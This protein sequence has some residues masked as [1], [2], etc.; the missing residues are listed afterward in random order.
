MRQ[1]DR[2]FI[3]LGVAILV[4]V[5]G[6][7][8]AFFSKAFDPSVGE[9]AQ[10][11][12]VTEAQGED[13]AAEQAETDQE[14]AT[15]EEVTEAESATTEED[16][17]SD[18]ADSD[19][20]DSE[21]AASDSADAEESSDNVVEATIVIPASDAVAAD[22]NGPS[23]QVISIFNR[24]GCA[25]CHV[26]PGIPGA[27]GQIGPNLSEI[28]AAA[29]DRIDGLS[30]EE[31]IHQSIVD[32]NAFIAPECPTGECPAGVMLQS[33]AQTF[34][35][36]DIDTIVS[37]LATL[38]TDKEMAT[39]AADSTEPVVL[40]TSLPAESVLEPFMELPKDPADPAMIA[41]GKYLFFDQRLS[42]NNSL[43][44]ASC[45]QPDNAFTDGQAL[46][47]GYPSTNYFRNTPTLYNTVF[48]NYLYSDGRMDGGDMPTLVRD[49]LTEAHFMSMDGRLMFERLKQVPEYVA[50]FDEVFGGEPSFGKVLNSITAYVQ[51]LNSPPSAYDQYLAGDTSALSEDAIAGLELF[52]GKAQCSGCHS[53][54]LLSDGEFYNIG[55]ETDVA[56]FQDPERHLT[57]RRFFRNFGVPNYRNL[58]EDVG[59]YALTLKEEDWGKFHTPSL[60]EV[61]R[62]A[63]YM[64]NGSLETLMD[65]VQFYNN[66]GGS[67]QTA[68]L[69][70]LDLSDE[71]MT[72]LVAFLESLSSETPAVEVPELPA[73]GLM[74]LGDATEPPVAVSFSAPVAADAEGAAGDEAATSE[75]SS[76]QTTSEETASEEATSDAETADTEAADT[77]TT[78]TATDSAETTAEPVEVT[79]E[80]IAAFAKG[81]CSA[82]HTIAGIP[83]A[84]GQIGPDLSAIGE[85][86]ATR[87]EGLSAAEY[88]RQSVAEPNAVIAPECP[89]GAC[90]PNLMPATLI[91]TLTDEELTQIVD[92][93]ASL[94]GGQ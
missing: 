46:S 51:S 9:V 24:G 52:E 82:C 40:D 4:L 11:A 45:H 29:A 15:Q 49:H 23:A 77:A 78:D 88:I 66:G 57:F 13:E 89:T 42:G 17:A 35:E 94:R 69:E 41:L 27:N 54:A 21:S 59:L 63:P 7:F 47:K 12:P 87:V 44:C 16:T 76:D 75:E 72:Q 31:Y 83:G 28:G 92:Y 74:A 6:G 81:T 22:A 1:N 85:A 84:V 50:L 32:P 25:G 65:V 19:S 91:D 33:F 55:V 30:A 73:Y 80:I 18:S 2:L 60:R 38:G 62:T 86:G 70:A 53:D 43:S 20:A 58:N 5:I 79:D 8:L 14:E 64:H 56:I 39:E 93:L 71:E 48:A 37:Y 34:S 67:S 61:A 68:G 10:P 3:L 26:I 36:A 90:L